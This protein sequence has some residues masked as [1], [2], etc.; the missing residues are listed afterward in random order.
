MV[1]VYSAY[2]AGYLSAMITSMST[3]IRAFLFTLVILAP[4]ALFA[5]ESDGTISAT[6][7]NALVCHDTTC[8]SPTPGVLNFRPTGT[9]PVTIEDTDGIDGIGWGN[10]IGWINFDPTGPEEVLID[11]DTGV[12]SGKAWAQA[13]GWVNFSVTG[14]SVSI[15][16]DGEFT[17]YAWTGGPNGG[18]I[19]FDCGTVGACVTTDWRPIPAREDE[20]GGASGGST[21]KCDNIAG[22]QSEVPAGL[23]RSGGNCVSVI[24]QCPNLAGSQAVV[25]TP[26]YKDT[27]GLCLL[28]NVDYCSNIDGNQTSVPVGLT[29][30][31]G[32]ACVESEDVPP[33]PEVVERDYCPN[34][35]DI[36]PSLP[37]GYVVDEMGMCVPETTDYCPNIEGNQTIVP[38]GLKIDSDGSCVTLPPEE[39]PTIPEIEGDREVIAY[40]FVPKAFQVPLDVPFLSVFFAEEGGLL[41]LIDGVSIL[42]S[43]LGLG[44]LGW[45]FFLV[46]GLIGNNKWGVVYNALSKA[47]LPGVTVSLFTGE[48]A[49]VKTITTDAKGTFGFKVKQG[50]YRIRIDA[51]GFT[52]PSGLLHGNM[53][54]TI[55]K[56]SLTHLYFGEP[57]ALKSMQKMELNIPVDP[58]SVA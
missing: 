30:T 20:G 33:L 43:L 3:Y 57:F 19:L 51:P 44:A 31:T 1:G 54:D 38:G 41:P 55:G 9:T 37:A 21:D 13:S 18:W 5:S 8:T 29:V 10:E 28:S 56:S 48:G 6:N 39:V 12:L 14:Q 50:V 17:G 46:P 15:N 34:L 53:Q 16:N 58:S 25:P 40:S 11:P 4:V 23:T 26:F 49:L 27:G 36:Q 7:K 24:D 2:D 47:P 22:N 42:L 52:F 45:L 32:G 35:F